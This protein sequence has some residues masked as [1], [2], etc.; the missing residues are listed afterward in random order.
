MMVLCND[1]VVTE[2]DGRESELPSAPLN[3]EY[4]NNSIEK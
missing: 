1:D 3:I 4:D 2:N